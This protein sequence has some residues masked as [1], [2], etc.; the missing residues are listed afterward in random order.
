MHT[1]WRKSIPAAVSVLGLAATTVLAG[2]ASMAMPSRRAAS[3]AQPATSSSI[4]PWSKAESTAPAAAPMMAQAPPTWQ[5]IQPVAPLASAEVSPW[6]H[7]I[8]YIGASLPEMH[9]GKPKETTHPVMQPAQPR[10]DAI[11]LSVP[12]GPPSPEFFIFAAQM[13]EKQG[14]LPQAR[15]NLQRALSMWPGNADL[16]RAAARMEDR[17]SNLP[18]AEN[19]YQQAVTANPQ[20]AAALNDLGLCLA[21]EGKLEPS[22][23]VLEQAIHL[24]PDKPLYR[25]NAATV[26]VEMRQ[27]QRALA[28]LAAVHNPADANFNLGQLLVDRGRPG[29]GAMYFQTALQLNPAMQQAQDAIA[30]LGGQTNV[31]AQTPVA[32]AMPQQQ[33]APAVP[34][35]RATA[36]RNICRPLQANP[37]VRCSANAAR[38]RAAAEKVSDVQPVAMSARCD[39]PRA[40]RAATRAVALRLALPDVRCSAAVLPRG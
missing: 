12:T 2:P 27:D 16:L 40:S 29:D 4:W 23:Q 30:K 31:A 33:F 11:S 3:A 5:G 18:L 21:R 39:H 22:L 8:K 13:C 1:A 20:N 28:H 17:Q 15:Q 6:K 34:G 7:P 26:L 14:D 38:V 25:N 35:F 9:I 19:L 37:A 24:Q 10:T 32:P 36:R